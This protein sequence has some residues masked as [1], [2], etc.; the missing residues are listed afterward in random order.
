MLLGGG[1]LRCRMFGYFFLVTGTD[2]RIYSAG[3]LETSANGCSI[4]LNLALKSKLGARATF[5]VFR[6]FP[7]SKFW[8]AWPYR[9]ILVL[10]ILVI[11]L[12]KLVFVCSFREEVSYSIAR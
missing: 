5:H 7:P 11:I 2:R 6:I 1:K 4:V 12:A 8:L 9:S 3:N 10:H